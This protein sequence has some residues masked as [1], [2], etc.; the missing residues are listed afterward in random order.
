M[1]NKKIILLITLSISQYSQAIN[2]QILTNRDSAQFEQKQR[3]ESELNQRHQLENQQQ[4]NLNNKIID[5]DTDEPFF[6]I[7]NINLLGDTLL[8]SSIKSK[9]TSSYHSHCLTLSKI[10]YVAKIITNHYIELGY[11]TSQAFIPEQGLTNKKLIIKIIEG[12]IESIDIENSPPRLVNMIFPNHIGAALNLRDLEQ[13]LEQLN[14]SSSAKYTI[15]IQ[16]SHKNGYS[17]IFVYKKSA[18]IPLNGQLS[19][20]NSGVRA[21]GKQL[22]TGNIVADSLLGIGEQWAF[23]INTD[24]DITHSHYSRY[25]AASLYVPY[26]Y[27]SYH[28][29]LYQNKTLQ[30]FYIANTLYPYEGRNT[31][32]QLDI[33]RLVYRDSKQRFTLQGSLKHKNANTQLAQQTLE[34]S[35]PTLS[36][37]NL[38]PQ[39]STI[40]GNGYFT[41]NP[42]FEWGVSIFG[43]SP[44]TIAEDAPRSHYRKISLS[45]SYQIYLNQD[46]FYLTSFYGQYTPDNLYS[47]ERINIGGQY[48]V[49]GYKEQSLSGN[50]GFYWRNELD[51]KIAST[52][53]GQWHLLAALDYGLVA[54]DK[55][56]IERNA[57]IGGAAGISFTSYSHFASRFLIS[58]PLSYPSLL[59]PDNW[60]MYWSVSFAI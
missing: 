9:L 23:S 3:L 47:I 37:I 2:T 1:I 43:A 55:Y 24:L 33:N 59:K 19:I 39:Y 31:N 32:Q 28:Y 49:R 57:L 26:G 12:K 21:T 11:V 36:S 42:T 56:Q 52:S 54:S 13:G 27:W 4:F 48:S 53:I 58:K 40:L 14:R 20:D 35:S 51:S 41:F 25:Y 29:Q 34:I 22:I 10:K 5:E 45:S 60:T 44:D 8:S 46:V 17:R 16:P 38:N 6:Y 7:E 15:D 50:R 30:P 18:K